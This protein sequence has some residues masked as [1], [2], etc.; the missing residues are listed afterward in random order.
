[1]NEA[2]QSTVISSGVVPRHVVVVGLASYGL[3]GWCEVERL[4]SCRGKTTRH[5]RLDGSCNK[6]VR[7]VGQ[8]NNGGLCSLSY[9]EDSRDDERVTITRTDEVAFGGG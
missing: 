3:G 5:V 1:M 7:V 9:G 2:R 6:S 4:E 8:V